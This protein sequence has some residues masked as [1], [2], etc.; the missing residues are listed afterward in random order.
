MLQVCFCNDCSRPPLFFYFSFFLLC[1][2][3][4][5]GKLFHFLL[6]LLR[7]YFLS[8]SN[9]LCFVIGFPAGASHFIFIWYSN[10]ISISKWNAISISKWILFNSFRTC[11][12]A[13]VPTGSAMQLLL[14]HPILFLLFAYCLFEIRIWLGVLLSFFYGVVRISLIG[15]YCSFE[16]LIREIVVLSVVSELWTCEVKWRTYVIHWNH[17]HDAHYGKPNLCSLSYFI[18]VPVICVCKLLASISCKHV[19]HLYDLLCKNHLYKKIPNLLYTPQNRVCWD[20][21]ITQ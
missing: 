13:H 8:H 4:L 6:K 18:G 3:N 17:E 1:G 19:I 5:I 7:F 11:N 16:V 2:M 9:D 21:K 14:N 10:A 15:K 12:I 20:A